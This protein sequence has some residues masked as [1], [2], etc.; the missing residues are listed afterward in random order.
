M[1]SFM[2]N[3]SYQLERLARVAEPCMRLARS[4]MSWPPGTVSSLSRTIVVWVSCSFAEGCEGQFVRMLRSQ[5]MSAITGDQ[6][7]VYDRTGLGEDLPNH[8]G[9]ELPFGLTRTPQSSILVSG[10]ARWGGE[11]CPNPVFVFSW[12]RERNSLLEKHIPNLGAMSIC[13]GVAPCELLSQAQL[14]FPIV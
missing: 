6:V 11:P 5:A 14:E 2:R 1:A 10:I 9:E 12:A 13:Q 4:R 8:V 7:A 3:D